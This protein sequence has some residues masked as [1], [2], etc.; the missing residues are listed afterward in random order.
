M[1]TMKTL[2]MCLCEGRHEIPQATEGS[3]FKT[4]VDPLAVDR[5]EVQAFNSIWDKCFK[6]GILEY[7]SSKY[8]ELEGTEE[9]D[10]LCIP[11]GLSLDLY[12]TGLTVAL[13]AVLNV[14][15]EEGIKVTLYHVNRE[16]GTYYAQEVK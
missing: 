10:S 3:I 6:L 4:E 5:L 13:V 1:T 7:A 16:T 11:R 14:C 2:K 8:P 15:R 9:E 12:V